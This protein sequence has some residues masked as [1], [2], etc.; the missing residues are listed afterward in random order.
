[1]STHTDLV[2]WQK[3]IDLVELVYRLTKDFPDEEK[4]GLISQMRRS[5]VSIPSNI[6]EGHGRKGNGDFAHFLKIAFGSSSELETQLHIAFRLDYLN[7]KDYDET[8]AFLADVR[9]M[10]NGLI[11]H[12]VPSN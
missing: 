1:M 8:V 10:L 3:S 11:T 7:K 9:K 4:F 5:A 2:V 6:A 12:I